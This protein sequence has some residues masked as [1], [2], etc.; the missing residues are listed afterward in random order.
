MSDPIDPNPPGAWSR[1]VV[2]G[3]VNGV[4][5][6]VMLSVIQVFGLFRPEQPLNQNSIAGN[7]L[8]GVVFGF[9]IYILELWRR[10]RRDKAVAAADAR[11]P[12]E[13]DDGR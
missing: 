3:V 2:R 13:R 5:F 6:A 9:A 7:L 10:Q 12:E 4:V 1:P 11:Q 8:A